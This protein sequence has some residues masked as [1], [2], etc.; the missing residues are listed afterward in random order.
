MT[1][2]EEVSPA[3]AALMREYNHTT[4]EMLLGWLS[5]V[6]RDQPNP[7]REV[8]LWR[9]RKGERELRCLTIY[10]PIGIDVRLMEGD[11]FRRTQLV[12]AAPAV[13]LIEEEWRQKLLDVGWQ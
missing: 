10:L 3:K 12:K 5:D 9:V 1:A 2:A 11:G 8:E 6:V 7:K 13:K 4:Q